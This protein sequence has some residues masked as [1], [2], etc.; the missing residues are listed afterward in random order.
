MLL[1]RGG[2]QGSIQLLPSRVA[3]SLLSARPGLTS[4]VS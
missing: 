4:V 3:P 1:G 2:D